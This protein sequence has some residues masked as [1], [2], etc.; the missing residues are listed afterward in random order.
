[1][2]DFPEG[3]GADEAADAEVATLA[4]AG[5]DGLRDRLE[6]AGRWPASAVRLRRRSDHRGRVVAEHGGRAAAGK[7]PRDRSVKRYC[8]GLHVRTHN[9][10]W[11]PA[12][13]PISVVVGLQEVGVRKYICS[14]FIKFSYNKNIYSLPLQISQRLEILSQIMV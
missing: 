14:N 5:G 10:V 9:M 12:R 8:F 11:T 7:Q 2:V 1:M 4:G 3:A 13:L 6:L